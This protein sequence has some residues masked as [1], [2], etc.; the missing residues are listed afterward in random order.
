MVAFR[1]SAPIP[2]VTGTN[3]HA[4]PVR[5]GALDLSKYWQIGVDASTPTYTNG[6][7]LTGTPWTEQDEDAIFE[8]WSPTSGG[9]SGGGGGAVTDELVKV[10]SDDTTSGYLSAK[11]VSG[12]GITLSTLNPAG[13]ETL[14]VA[15]IGEAYV[16][17]GSSPVTGQIY[18]P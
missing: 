1:F 12:A 6:K 15:T 17:F 2:V 3:Y 10:S 9:A 5:T 13:S 11:L 8:I 16:S 4:I 7:V 18:V 14:E